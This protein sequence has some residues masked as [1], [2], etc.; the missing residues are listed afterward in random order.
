M[1]ELLATITMN[2]SEGFSTTLSRYANML[3][4]VSCIYFSYSC[5]QSAVDVDKKLQKRFLPRAFVTS[6]CVSENETC[7]QNTIT[8]T[9]YGLE[10]LI[11]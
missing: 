1:L 3:W 6:E 5:D 9:R 10:Q 2:A 8:G 11:L 4:N 7:S